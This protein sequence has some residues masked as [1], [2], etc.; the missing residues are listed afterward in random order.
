MDNRRDLLDIG[1]LLFSQRG[2]EAVGIQELVDAVGVTK[3]TLYH[4]F[5]NKRGLLDAILEDG[6]PDS[7]CPAV[8]S[9][10]D[11]Q[12]DIVLT[13][14]RITEAYFSFAD[15]VPRFFR[16]Q[17]GLQYAPPESESYLAVSPFHKIFSVMQSNKYFL[18]AESDHGNMRGR[19]ALYTA[20]FLGMIN[21]NAI[22]LI[23]E[24]IHPNN[25]LIYKT[26]H[27]FMHGIFS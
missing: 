16:F 3:P 23:N 19:S 17:L 24:S 7:S 15:Q 20:G 27:Q 2:Y 11:Y 1:L 18:Q 26:V 6:F 10:A 4:Y 21:A 5:Q 12:H 8:L 9:A 14:T 25:D 22:Q 13:L